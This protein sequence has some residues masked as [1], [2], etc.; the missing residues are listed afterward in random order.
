V[1][2]VGFTEGISRMKLQPDL[3]VTPEGATALY[4]FKELKISTGFKKLALFDTFSAR[5]KHNEN[6]RTQEL[7]S[8]NTVKCYLFYTKIYEFSC[9][10]HCKIQTH[11]PRV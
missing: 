6:L 11:T 10:G 4:V 5:V 8:A 2:P 1:P 3:A 7:H 9:L